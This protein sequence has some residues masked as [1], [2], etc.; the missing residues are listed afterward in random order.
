MF[1]RLWKPEVVHHVLRSAILC[2]FAVY[3]AQLAGSGKLTLYIAPRMSD[4]VK[5]SA[6]ALYAVAA[7]QAYLALAV[8][9][10]KRHACECE[11]PPSAS[12]WKNIIAYGLFVLP[13]ALGFLSPDA[14]LGSS[15][16]EKKGMN[17]SSSSSLKGT[18]DTQK[19][20][21]DP[22]PPSPDP[23]PS[24]PGDTPPSGIT[25]NQ[26]VPDELDRL[27][28]ADEFTETYANYGKKIYKEPLIHVEEQSFI[29]TLTT[30]DLFRK[31]FIGKE[32]E[33][34]GFVYRTEDMNKQQFV[35]GRF[36]M[37]C[38][39][40]DASPYG[41]LVHFDHANRY[42]N[43]TW[44]KIRGTLDQTVFN[45]NEILVIQAQKIQKITPP[46][47][48]YVYPNFDFGL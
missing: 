32:V 1:K 2:G 40:A 19:N 18:A 29:E 3:I 30:L 26:P 23:D 46:E 22:A 24:A 8:L 43:D 34:S 25:S 20:A 48:P 31:A 45:E 33:I 28:P 9:W 14:A 35:I 6:I 38:C 13:L 42:P 11:H 47:S 17:L 12:L 39:S 15:L 10:G 41:M 21:S 5:W 4:Y 16:A 37:N 27:F 44:I 7:Y 36:I